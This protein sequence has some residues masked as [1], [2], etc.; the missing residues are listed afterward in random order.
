MP[1]I[2]E[3]QACRLDP[4]TG[5]RLPFQRRGRTWALAGRPCRLPARVIEDNGAR[6][7]EIYADGQWIKDEDQAA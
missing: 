6:I 3:F 7:I 4:R 1:T 5:P 2:D